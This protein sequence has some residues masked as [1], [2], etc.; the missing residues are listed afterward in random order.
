MNWW[1]ALW[2]GFL[3]AELP[4]EDLRVASFNVRYDSSGDR[5]E[6]DWKARRDLVVATIGKMKP[7]VLG[8]QEA[9]HHQLA[10]L[11]GKLPELAVLGVGRDDGKKRGEYSPIF[12]RRDRFTPD[13]EE[14][15]TFWLSD[16]PAEPGSMT[17]GN[18]IPR[19]CTWA[20]LQDR[21]GG[22]HIYVFN[23][24]WDHRSQASR[25]RAG[26]MILERIAA[27]KYPGDPVVLMGDFNATEANPAV[28]QFLAVSPAKD[29]E[30]PPVSGP[31]RS[32]F[33]TLHSDSETRRTFH[34]WEGGTNG[35]NTID[36]IL[37]S[38]NWAIREAWIEEHHKGSMWPSDHFPVGAVLHKNTENGRR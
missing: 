25:E 18:E 8:V 21:L 4:A 32:T 30:G 24:H 5:G 29:R 14:Q 12:Y 2:L 34:G 6:R 35:R 10:Y 37:V 33:L 17:W 19:I 15:G 26:R 38:K 1:T 9:L 23:T 22:G 11:D 3:I 20:R 7:D 36:H 27:R 28:A 13:A 16:S 31:F